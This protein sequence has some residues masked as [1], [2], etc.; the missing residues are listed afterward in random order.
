MINNLAKIV[1]NKG[2]SISPLLIDSSNTDGT[3]L[4]NASV[5][6]DTNGDI[7][8]NIRHVHYTLYH[9]EFNQ[10]F[11]CKWG[12]L[13]YLNPEDD[14]SLKTG[15][16]LCKLNP[17]TLEVESYSKVNTSKHDIPPV[18]EF[19]GLED[20][21]VVRWEDKLYI[22][23]VRRDVKPDGEGRMELCEVELIDGI[24]H[25][26]TRDRIEVNPHTYLEKNWMPILDLPY[27]FIRWSN[28][29]EIVKVNPKTQTSEVVVKKDQYLDLPYDL[30]GG[31]QVITLDDHYVTLTHDCN[32]FHHPGNHKDA[33][34][35]HRFAFWDK[36]WN[37]VKLS[38]MFSFMDAQIEFSCGLAEHEDNLLISFGYQD[39]AAYLLKMPKTIL[40]ELEWENLP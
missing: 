24:Y 8:C 1:I 25:E 37:L 30:R 36:D 10:K 33:Q 38:K 19:H 12:A 5:F 13:A 9:S 29:L 18:W 3:G 26:L 17:D 28:P 21:R 23:G 40:N 20:A 27:H 39:N 34:Y 35:Y 22:C 2:G 11:Y 14:I 7:L 16:Y 6:K 32:F 4:C 15:N 31:S